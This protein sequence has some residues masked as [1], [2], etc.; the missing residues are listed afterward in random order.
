MFCVESGKG[1][2]F[3][4]RLRVLKQFYSSIVDNSA[5]KRKDKS[6]R[7]PIG[8]EAIINEDIEI[9]KN[10][11]TLTNPFEDTQPMIVFK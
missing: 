11:F 3:C 4:S 6:D 7:V 2:Y 8:L 9:L 1:Y 5:I 10:D